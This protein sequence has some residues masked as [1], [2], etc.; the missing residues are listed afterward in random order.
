MS[1]PIIFLLRCYKRW[2]SPLLGSRCRFQPSCSDYARVAVARFGALRGG[3]LGLWR[4][5]R[6]QPLCTGGYDPVPAEFHW[7]PAC[8]QASHKEH[9]HD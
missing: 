1:R 2:L 5:L 8:A 6:C 3:W 4:I 7:W 9:P